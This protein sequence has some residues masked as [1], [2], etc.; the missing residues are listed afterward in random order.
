MEKLRAR[1]EAVRCLVRPATD[2]RRLPAGVDTARADLATGKDIDRR[3]RWRRRRDPCGGCHQ[4]SFAGRLLRR[5]CNRHRES[6]RERFMAGRFVWFTSAAWR[7]SDRAPRASPV[8]E[9]TPPHPVSTYGKSKLQGEKI[10]RSLVP[11]AVI[12]RPPVVYG[13]RDTDVFQILKA[14]AAAWYW[15]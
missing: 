12:I 2:T 3:A 8:D 14:V 7:R 4:S 15:K 6:S 10:A 11:D 13:P 9:N 5:Q 1:G